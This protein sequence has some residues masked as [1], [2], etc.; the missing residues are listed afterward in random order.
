MNHVREEL[1]FISTTLMEDKR[2]IYWGKW[3][4]GAMMERGGGVLGHFGKQ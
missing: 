2:V 3:E 1:D 4:T